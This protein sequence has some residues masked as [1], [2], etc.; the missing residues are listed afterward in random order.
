MNFIF[1]V[2]DG[3]RDTIEDCDDGK[4]L[5]LDN[6]CSDLPIHILF[7]F[8]FDACLYVLNSSSVLRFS[9]FALIR[10]DVPH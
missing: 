5:N 9:S 2:G 4:N 6:G 8:V 7:R 10:V 3:V 1:A